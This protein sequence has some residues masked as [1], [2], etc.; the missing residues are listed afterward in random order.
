[1]TSQIDSSS[2]LINAFNHAT[3]LK[4]ALLSDDIK[5][6][7]DFLKSENEDMQPFEQF[8]AETIYAYHDENYNYDNGISTI[9]IEKPMV[10]SFKNDTLQCVIKRTTT[11]KDSDEIINTIMWYYSADGTNLNYENIAVDIPD[12][13]LLEWFPFIDL[14]L[15]KD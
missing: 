6:M 5:V 4:E 11:L 15:F 3:K 7:Y 14:Q 10:Y 2:F 13:K 1:M 8:K 9:S 12:A